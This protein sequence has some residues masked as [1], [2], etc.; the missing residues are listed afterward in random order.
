MKEMPD[1]T[2][3]YSLHCVCKIQ[4][5]KLWGNMPKVAQTMRANMR[6][7]GKS[8]I[9]TRMALSRAHASSKVSQSPYETTF[10]FTRYTG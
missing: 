1:S 3:V 6:A 9:A 8:A 5:G 10:K 7:H 4:K 2:V